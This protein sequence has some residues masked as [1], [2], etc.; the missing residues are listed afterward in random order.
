MRDPYA[1]LIPAE[2][3]MPALQAPD[4][5]VSGTQDGLKK[6]ACCRYLLGDWISLALIVV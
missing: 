4:T 5:R 1:F 3:E 6:R 2:G